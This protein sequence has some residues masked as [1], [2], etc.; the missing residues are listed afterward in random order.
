MLI[1]KFGEKEVVLENCVSV[2]GEH[3]LGRVLEL[4]DP[5]ILRPPQDHH[6]VIRAGGKRRSLEDH[7]E[8]VICK[9]RR[10]RDEIPI[11][12]VSHDKNFCFRQ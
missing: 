12:E 9:R 1:G 5:T 10:A 3:T 8:N 7:V 6:V 11:I 2:L 4:M